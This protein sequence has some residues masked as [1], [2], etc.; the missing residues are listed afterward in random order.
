GDAQ[1]DVLVN[2]QDLVG[3]RFNDVL[4]GDAG[5]NRITGG[6]G[7]DILTRGG[8]HHTLLFRPREG[9]GGRMVDFNGAGAGAGDLLLFSGFAAGATFTQV[10]VTHWQ[11]NYGASHEVMTFSN[12]AVIHPSDFLFA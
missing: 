11:V 2:I 4:S 7:A 3:S 1:G 8:G 10:D 12:A 9:V 5:N 6:L